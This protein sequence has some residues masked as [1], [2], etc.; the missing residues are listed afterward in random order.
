[1]PEFLKVIESIVYPT[2]SS[3]FLLMDDVLV[4]DCIED[5]LKVSLEEV[6]EEELLPLSS[7]PYLDAKASVKDIL[8]QEAN[9]PPITLRSNNLFLSF[10]T[11]IKVSYLRYSNNTIAYALRVVHNNAR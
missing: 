5:V 2:Y 3:L 1:M 8:E 10:I 6:D 9:N 11:S 4:R 7:I